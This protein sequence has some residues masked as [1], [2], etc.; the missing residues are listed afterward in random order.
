MARD[1]FYVI[2]WQILTY[3]YKQLKDGNSVDKECISSN[4]PYYSINEKYWAFIVKTLA[5]KGYIDGVK[6]KV[7]RYENGTKDIQ[8]LYL[9]RC[10]ITMDGIA[11]LSSDGFMEK[12]KELY[13]DKKTFKPL[14]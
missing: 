14:V 9:D 5:E 10:E 3:L 1:D 13:E 7:T 2:V 8:I 12:V 4:S 11:Y 6:V